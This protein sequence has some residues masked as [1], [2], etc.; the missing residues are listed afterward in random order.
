MSV[1]SVNA[2]N[3][4][5]SEDDE[6]D[7]TYVV[8]YRIV[9]TNATDGVRT[10]FASG[11]LP[12]YGDTYSFHGETN[13]AAF[14]R[15]YSNFRYEDTEHRLTR[16]IDITYSSKPTWKKEQAAF[17]DPLAE[18]W[19]IRGGFTDRMVLTGVDKD[20]VAIT[21]SADEQKF[22]QIPGGNPVIHFEGY[23]ATISLTTQSQAVKKVNSATI[24]GLAAR[25][26]FLNKWDY[27]ILYHDTT[28]YVKHVMDFEVD[29]NEWNEVFMDMGTRTMLVVGTRHVYTEVQDS[30][31]HKG[32]REIHLDGN[33]QE[34][35]WTA[36]PNGVTI[37][38]EIIK[39]FDF[40][41]IP[42]LPT[43][44]PIAFV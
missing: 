18:P 31:D 28:P 29:V 44:L 23:T 35:D 16:L 14:Y 1:S 26:V 4:T 24:W 13:T 11:L 2:I 25:K 22:F 20:G 39:E 15:T 19:K 21:N 27:E 3:L 9:C 34:N 37:T 38:A 10:C 7:S 32:R 40:T 8:T 33:G 30:R 42:G 5:A 17:A 6:G 43:T 12:G 36:N 41:T